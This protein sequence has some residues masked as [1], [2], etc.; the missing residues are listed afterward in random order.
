MKSNKTK[1]KRG[2]AEG[3]ENIGGKREAGKKR[4]GND[5]GDGQFFWAIYFFLRGKGT[6]PVSHSTRC[7]SGVRIDRP[8]FFYDNLAIAA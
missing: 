5:G 3:R 4:Q 2:K 8:L 6:N 1:F 7:K